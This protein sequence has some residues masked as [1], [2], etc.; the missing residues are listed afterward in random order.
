MLCKFDEIRAK[1]WLNLV[2]ECLNF[3]TASVF[4][5]PYNN[6]FGVIYCNISTCFFLMLISRVENPKDRF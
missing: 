5:V 4:L 6:V 2:I 1:L 3:T